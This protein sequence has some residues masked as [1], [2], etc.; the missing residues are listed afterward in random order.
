MGSTRFC[1]HCPWDVGICQSVNETQATCSDHRTSEDEFQA[2]HDGQA[3]FDCYHFV[4]WVSGYRLHHLRIFHVRVFVIDW[5]IFFPCT[6]SHLNT[7]FL[8]MTFSRFLLAII[9]CSSRYK[10]T[11]CIQLCQLLLLSVDPSQCL[12]L[13]YRSRF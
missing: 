8:K 4:S 3:L 5:G 7:S 10:T 6:F 2:N 11:D 12:L 9:R 13:I 1:V